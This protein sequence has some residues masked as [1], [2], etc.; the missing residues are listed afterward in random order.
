MKNVNRHII[1][2]AVILPIV[3]MTFY[4]VALPNAEGNECQG[5]D[6]VQANCPNVH[7][8]V[9]PA[10]LPYSPADHTY[11]KFTEGDG[12]WESFPCFGKCTGGEI[13]S[14]TESLIFEDNKKIVKYMA[15]NK[16]CRWPK[17]YYLAIGVCHQLAN[18]SLFHTGKTVKNARMYWWSSF[19]YYTYGDCFWPLKQYCFDNCREASAALGPWQPGIPP[20]CGP[21]MSEKRTPAKPD[22]ECLLYA[23]HFGTLKGVKDSDGM[24]ALFKSYRNDLFDLFYM[25]RVGDRTKGNYLPILLKGHDELLIGKEALDKRLLKMDKL[26][27]DSEIIQAYNKLFNDT[28]STLSDRLPPDIYAQFFGLQKGQVVDVGWF[29]PSDE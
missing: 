14:D 24:K 12:R 7:V 15:S 3:L 29:L 13:L 1:F 6:T 10:Y 22:D 28:L 16:P 18:R 19:F 4:G 17:L 25:Q 2:G 20:G 27:K 5:V 23:K 8:E 26:D 9:R 11:V 21:S